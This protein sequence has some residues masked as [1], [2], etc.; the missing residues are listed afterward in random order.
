MRHAAGNRIAH[1]HIH[2]LFYSGISVGW[3]W[4]YGESVARDNAIAHNHVHDVGQGLLSDLGGI[5]L[6]GVSAGTTVRNNLVHDVRRYHYGGWGIYP[7]EGTSH[8]VI[9]DN[10]C[11]DTDSQALHQHYGRENLVRNN[12]FAWG[13]RG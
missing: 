3:S 2:D 12:I 5:Y 8:V 9:E 6:L 11:Y 10:V 4:G 7:D 13:A 1:N